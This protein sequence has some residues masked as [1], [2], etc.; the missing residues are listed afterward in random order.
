[1]FPNLCIY[2]IDQD[3]ERQ[4]YLKHIIGFVEGE[5]CVVADPTE[6]ELPSLDKGSA[7]V[8]VFLGLDL[9]PDQRLLIA[10]TLQDQ[11]PGL[12]AFQLYDEERGLPEKLE[13]CDNVLGGFKMPCLYDDL[14][15]L[16]HK[17]QVYQELKTSDTQTSRPVEL[18]RSL[19]GS[20]R[21]T[22]RVNKMIEQVADSE[23][24]VLILGESGTGKEVVARKLH[25]HSVRRGKPFVPVNCGA[26]PGD[27]LE[28]ELFGH[29]KGAFTGAISARQGRFE[30]AEG[31]TLFLDEI[32]DM[33]MPMQV[34]L[35]R[36]LQERTFERVGSNRTIPCNVRIIAATHRNL[37]DAIKHGDFREDLFYRLNVF[38]IEMPPLRDRVEDIPVLVN[39]LIHRIENEKRGSV[40]L[41]PAAI[42]ALSHYRWP[43]NVRELANLI[44]RLAI[45]HPYGVVDV[46][47]LPEKF[48]PTG[49]LPEAMQLPQVTLE[50]EE[51]G[52]VINAP[53]LPNDGLDLKAHLNSLEQSLI[54]QALDESD[55]IVAHAAKRLHMRRTTLVEKL[56]KY[57]LQR[58]TES[59]GI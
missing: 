54:Q 38:P 21:A 33:S 45:L 28:S 46:A 25:F 16:T 36:V 58:H 41:T 19:S 7:C 39:D 12:P 47:D 6:I 13:G 44:E 22:R 52:T 18:F 11:F 23:A 9:E 5:L 15:A 32:G 51:P 37:E 55:G 20:S 1:M 57:G 2:L 35:L 26:I 10:R 34:K 42:A 31:G 24:T 50:G 8:A 59:P 56:R 43:G 29:E 40:R 14:M 27:L 53:R 30:M 4:S 17:A 49:E 48:R 3:S